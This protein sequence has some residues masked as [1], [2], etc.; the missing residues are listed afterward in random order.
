MRVTVCLRVAVSFLV[1]V[2]SAV[3]WNKGGVRVPVAS[4]EGGRRRCTLLVIT[5]V[6][7]YRI[8]VQEKGG[9]EGKK[10]AEINGAS[11]LPV[12][13]STKSDRGI[14]ITCLLVTVTVLVLPAWR[15]WRPCR[16]RGGSEVAAP[17][18]SET[19]D[20]PAESKDC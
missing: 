8:R 2:E 13:S 12:W 9:M 15:R 10:E 19:K 3:I 20:R 16:G 11:G 14:K 17:E 1:I 5:L 6:T 18:V 7:V 4:M